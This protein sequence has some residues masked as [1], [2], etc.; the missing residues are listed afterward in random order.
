MHSTKVITLLTSRQAFQNLAIIGGV[1]F[2]A[3]FCHGGSL[4]LV[5]ILN[6]VGAV[7]SLDTNSRLATMVVQQRL[8]RGIEPELEPNKFT[9]ISVDNID[10]LQSHAMVSS[11][12]ATC[13]W[14]GT[15]IQCVQPLPLSATLTQN[16]L[17]QVNSR[18]R[19]LESP[20]VLPAPKRHQRTITEGSSPQS[21]AALPTGLLSFPHEGSLEDIDTTDYPSCPSSLTL[22]SFHQSVKEGKSLTSL[23]KGLFHCVWLKDAQ[24]RNQEITLPGIPSLINCVQALRDETEVSKV[25]YVDILSEIADCK[26]TLIKI[27]ANLHRTFV[28]EMNQRWVFVVGDAK[29]YDAFYALRLRY[30]DHLKW[31]LPFPG[32]WHTLWNY[33]KVLMKIYSDAG[34]VQLA[35]EAGHRAE[36]LTTLIQCS[37]FRRT[38][39][40][41]FQAYTAFYRFFLHLYSNKHKHEQCG[42][43]FSVEGDSHQVL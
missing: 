11:L 38:H 36:T 37:N 27:I 35:K 43:L 25:V 24:S 29:V 22:A 28:K 18:K 33:Q 12:D 17:F 40:L 2:T 30:R 42:I 39:N 34:L 7:S 15:S 8:K 16:E 6:R 5:R 21:N 9:V 41:L 32:D 23:Q 31:L 10:I 1:T 26:S 3:I 13:S 4:E 19:A 20:E 14:H